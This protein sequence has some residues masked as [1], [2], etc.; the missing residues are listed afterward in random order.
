MNGYRL[1]FIQRVIC[2]NH[3][4]H[5]SFEVRLWIACQFALESNFGTSPLAA[6]N[7]NYCG[8]KSPVRRINFCDSTSKEFASYSSLVAC[9]VDYLLWLAWNHFTVLDCKDVNK[10][11]LRMV[12]SVYC[13][14]N[15]YIEKID[16]I[17]LQAFETLNSDDYV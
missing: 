1:D 6:D 11:K 5:F 17:Y 16:S 7:E 2:I 15:G 13:P 3:L 9:V 4:R 10:F 8:M 14:E 12:A